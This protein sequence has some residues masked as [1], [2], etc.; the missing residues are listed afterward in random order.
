MSL[1]GDRTVGNTKD[2]RAV[3]WL[4][5]WI[6]VSAWC[7]MSG[8][9]LSLLGRLNF[10]GYC[11]SFFIL[12]GVLWLCRKTL[13]FSGNKVGLFPKPPFRR[14]RW[15]P[16]IWLVLFILVFTGGLIHHPVNYD[17]L[18]YRFTRVLHWC[19]EG[20]WH[21]IDTPNTRENLMASGYEW[22]MTPVFVFFQTD[23]LFFSLTS[24]PPCFCRDSS[25]RFFIDWASAR[26]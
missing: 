20:R 15:L 22:L 16:R 19:W 4:A 23:R 26:E 3:D 10:Y 12:F 1:G 18:S 5:L 11:G 8:W 24:S 14:R 6:L 17:H 2:G 7:T 9:L 25:F 13:G 21:W